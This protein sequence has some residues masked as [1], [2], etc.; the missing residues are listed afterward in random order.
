MFHKRTRW[1]EWA[2]ARHLAQGEGPGK[3]CTAKPTRVGARRV[4]SNPPQE[5]FNAY[6]VYIVSSVHHTSHFTLFDFGM[7]SHECTERGWRSKSVSF[8]IA[9]HPFLWARCSL[10]DSQASRLVSSRK[11]SCLCPSRDGTTGT[12]YR[13]KI[14]MW[15][16]QFW[17]QVFM[18]AQHT[19]HTESH[20]SSLPLWILWAQISPSVCFSSYMIVYFSSVEAGLVWLGQWLYNTLV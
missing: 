5:G 17:T 13:A 12:Q 8:S 20:L 15:L 10:I 7:R 6:F 19:L 3:V 16:L 18:V 11:H 14:F 9:F 4:L 1:L 2:T